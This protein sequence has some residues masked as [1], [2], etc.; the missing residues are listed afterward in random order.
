MTGVAT[1]HSP[2][3]PGGPSIE[4]EYRTPMSARYELG[5]RRVH[6]I[7]P[8]TLTDEQRVELHRAGVSHEYTVSGSTDTERCTGT[9]P[10]P[11]QRPDL[12]LPSDDRDDNQQ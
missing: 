7:G 8:I 1:V 4:L 10:P 9:V 6:P 2:T 3:E 11:G 12:P 5:Q